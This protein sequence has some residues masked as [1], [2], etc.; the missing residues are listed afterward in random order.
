MRS[1]PPPLALSVALADSSSFLLLFLYDGGLFPIVAHRLSTGGGRHVRAPAA[2]STTALR[3]AYE[4]R[5]MPKTL[6]ANVL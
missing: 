4:V 2:A 6:L 1:A 3:A 5:M